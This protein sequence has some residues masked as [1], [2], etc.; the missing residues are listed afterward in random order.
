MTS[1]KN[2]DSLSNSDGP[3]PLVM[4]GLVN[5]SMRLLTL[6]M[7]VNGLK[8]ALE[9]LAEE[10]TKITMVLQDVMT[11]TETL[12]RKHGNRQLLET[13]DLIMDEKDIRLSIPEEQANEHNHCT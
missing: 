6:N 9:N 12:R 3:N 4:R 2:Q 7:A 10:S 8:Q 11:L 5:P 1:K 13:V